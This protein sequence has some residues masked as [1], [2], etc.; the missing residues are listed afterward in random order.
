M[1][2]SKLAKYQSSSV[3]RLYLII[4]TA[5]TMELSVKERIESKI[6][7]NFVSVKLNLEAC[8]RDVAW[9]R[10]FTRLDHRNSTVTTHSACFRV[11]ATTQTEFARLTLLQEK[12]GYTLR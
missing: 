2:K 1:K 9:P 6:K 8:T 7:R 12:S 3:R 11:Q 4:K 10:R 5:E